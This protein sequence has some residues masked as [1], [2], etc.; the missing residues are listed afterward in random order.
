M[1]KNNQKY[2]ISVI[3]PTHN[4]KKTIEKC[5]K[6]I[7]L[8]KNNIKEVIVVDNCSKD[9][10]TTII[11]KFPCKLLRLNKNYGAGF[12]RNFGAK[13]A[14]GNLLL[15]V[16]G[17]IELSS[18]A[19]T[20]ILN[21][22]KKTKNISCVVGLLSKEN[23]C[24]NIISEYKN[25][26]MHY[27]VV[28]LPEYISTTV[29]AITSVKKDV[30]KKIGGYNPYFRA[31]EDIDFG[32]RLVKNGYKIYLNKK[33]QVKHLK[34]Y[35]LKTLLITDFKKAFYWARILLENLDIKKL[36]KRKKQTD[37]SIDFMINCYVALFLFLTLFAFLLFQTF[38][39]NITT[40]L[41]FAIFIFL[42]L[43]FWS[44]LRNTK[45]LK[46]ALLSIPITLVDMATISLGAFIGTLYY[47]LILKQR[48]H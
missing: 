42:N 43:K 6:S 5:L 31:V 45:G 8:L 13:K 30:F 38:L 18:Q 47:L 22:F 44:F 33:L 16:D 2:S 17:D 20:L 12:A 29:G 7:F 35:S 11:K 24:K 34:E 15:F 10:T 40:S 36:L 39:L 28:N 37:K 1:A 26:F 46:F 19:I 23:L 27:M 48:T 14:K 3:V 4:N 21:S 41:L 32:Q 25:L 9:G